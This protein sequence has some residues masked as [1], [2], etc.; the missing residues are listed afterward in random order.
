M[1]NGVYTLFTAGSLPGNLSNLAVSGL[2]GNSA[3]QTYSFA[4]S[5]GTAVTLTVTGNVGNL[6]WTGGTNGTWDNQTSPSWY[7]STSGSADVFTRATW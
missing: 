1:P 7:N 3:R 5:G 4:P 2:Y 6:T